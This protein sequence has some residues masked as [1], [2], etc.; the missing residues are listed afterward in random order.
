MNFKLAL[1]GL[2]SAALLAGCGSAPKL[3][4]PEGQWED[5]PFTHAPVPRPT[6]IKTSPSR[7]PDLVKPVVS[8]V[9]E[10]LPLQPP[11]PAR[12]KPR[13]VAASPA[14]TGAASTNDF[15]CSAN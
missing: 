5:M 11:K 2:L 10:A 8:P 15:K 12:R 9:P 7:V 13:P 1:S 4:T 3:S 14:T 6:A